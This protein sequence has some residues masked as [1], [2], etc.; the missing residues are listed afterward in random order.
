MEHKYLKILEYFK[1]EPIH[2]Q[3]NSDTT[4]DKV[5]QINM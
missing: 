2:S 3:E 5:Q 1:V 4:I